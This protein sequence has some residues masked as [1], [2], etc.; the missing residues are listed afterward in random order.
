[1]IV[2]FDRDRTDGVAMGRVGVISLILLCLS[3]PALAALGST[4]DEQ[5]VAAADDSFF[6]ASVASKGEAWKEF[7][8]E[9]ASLPV[10][11]G[12]EAIG[13]FYAKLYS[14]PGFSLSW[15][16]EFVK[17]MGDVAV[18]SGRYES[19]RLDA[20]GQD[21]KGTGTY[22]TVWQRQKDSGW[23]FSWDGGTADP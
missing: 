11:I 2:F 7:A 18:T 16:P 17:V 15:H 9:Q 10:G 21:K 1:M 5:A 4:P 20:A 23:R 12:K 8:D 14:A 6:R 3:G 22:V 13:T 19:H